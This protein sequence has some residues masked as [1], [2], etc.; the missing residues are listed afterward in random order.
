MMKIDKVKI[1]KYIEKI[2]RVVLNSKDSKDKGTNQEQ[3][4]KD[5]GKVFNEILEKTKVKVKGE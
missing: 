3:T 4:T 1:Y 5:N 2:D